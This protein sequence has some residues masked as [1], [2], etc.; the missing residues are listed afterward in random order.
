MS[1]IIRARSGLMGWW[2]ASEVIRGAS[3]ELKVAGPS[4][5]GIRRPDRHALPLATSPTRRQRFT[6]P[7]P[8]GAGSFVA[9]FRSLLCAL[10]ANRLTLRGGLPRLAAIRPIYKDSASGGN[11]AVTFGPFWLSPGQQLILENGKPLRLS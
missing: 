10:Q 11:T 8:A 2:E 9:P 6:H 4:M 3:L 5:L 7:P 1:S